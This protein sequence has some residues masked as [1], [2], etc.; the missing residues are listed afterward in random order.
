MYFSTKLASQNGKI[1]KYMSIDLE[2]FLND[3]L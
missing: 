3:R 2:A 1:E